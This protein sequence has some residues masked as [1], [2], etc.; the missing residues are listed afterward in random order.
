MKN[1]TIE[2]ALNIDLLAEAEL[3]F[4][5]IIDLI[6][7]YLEAKYHGNYGEFLEYVADFLPKGNEPEDYYTDRQNRKI[8]D[9][10]SL[11]N[12]CDRA[13]GIIEQSLRE[14]YTVGKFEDLLSTRS[15]IKVQKLDNGSIMVTLQEVKEI[16]DLSRNLTNL[17]KNS[18]YGAHGH[19]NMFA[20]M[21]KQYKL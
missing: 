16:I 13:I 10:N 20:D 18:L 21:K 9:Y 2:I 14:G 7:P 12:I 1:E 19:G 11:C 15:I 3:E 8:S 17:M 4:T 6:G 5:G